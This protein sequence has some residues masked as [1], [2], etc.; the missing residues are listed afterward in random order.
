MAPSTPQIPHLKDKD[1]LLEIENLSI[2]PTQANK[3]DPAPDLLHLQPERQIQDHHHQVLGD[4][5]PTIHRNPLTETIH[6]GGTR[7]PKREMEETE[8]NPRLQVFKDIDQHLQVSGNKVRLPTVNDSV[9]HE[10]GMQKD[11]LN[12]PPREIVVTKTPN[13]LGHDHLLPLDHP[14]DNPRSQHRGNQLQLS[15]MPPVHRALANGDTH[16]HISWTKQILKVL[17]IIIV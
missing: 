6:L 3:K 8:I 5:Q 7:D 15:N 13:S 14:G 4:H 17:N 12:E 10:A 11:T 16:S 2:P 1:L 9:I